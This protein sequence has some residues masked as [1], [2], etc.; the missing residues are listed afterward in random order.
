MAGP[1]SISTIPGRASEAEGINGIQPN[2]KFPGFGQMVGYIH[3][4]GLK[5]G[6]YST[7]WIA[8]YAGYTGCSSPF[9]NGYFPDSI[10]E[11]KRAYRYVGKYTFEAEDARQMAEWGI[12]LPEIRLAYDRSACRTDGTGAEAF[13]ERH[14]VT[15][16]PIRRPSTR[17]PTGQRLPT[18]GE[19]AAISGIPG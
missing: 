8:T 5:A 7:P 12:R 14:R 17:P 9:E 6:L 4:L 2:E 3:S 13:G 18:S 19:P 16:F 10:R 15:A 11:N 1:I